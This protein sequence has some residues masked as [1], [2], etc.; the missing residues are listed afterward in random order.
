MIEC[1]LKQRQQTAP[2]ATAAME[3]ETAVGSTAVDPN[4]ILAMMESQLEEAEA[5]TEIHA[6]DSSA[7]DVCR[8]ELKRY[9][10][11]P[12]QKLRRAEGD[13]MVYNNPL[14]WWEQH[15]SKFPNL[16]QLARAY[17]AVQATS[18]PSE[19]IFSL[20]SRIISNNRV[21]LDPTIAGKLLFVSKNWDW[22]EANGVNLL[23]ACTKEVEEE[24]E[25]QAEE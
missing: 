6:L 14:E 22:M 21:S 19:R 10:A 17:L 8:D 12:Y 16:A 24:E 18:A 25:D 1:E 2:A 5:E 23:Q 11:A 9:M 4:D 7:S 13:K 15:H 20:A 3:P